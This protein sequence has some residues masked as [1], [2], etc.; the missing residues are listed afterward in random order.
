MGN[1]ER[2]LGWYFHRA[3]LDG[4]R[5]AIASPHDGSAPPIRPRLSKK[6]LSMGGCGCCGQEMATAIRSFNSQFGTG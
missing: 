6:F 4:C 2:L 5:V 3:L 1:A